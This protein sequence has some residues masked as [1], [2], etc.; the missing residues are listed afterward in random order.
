MLLVYVQSA[1]SPTLNW[2]FHTNGAKKYIRIKKPEMKCYVN[3]TED[4]LDAQLSIMLST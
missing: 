4:S 1:Y 3:L 2:S